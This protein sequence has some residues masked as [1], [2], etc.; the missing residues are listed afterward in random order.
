M[1]FWSFWRKIDNLYQTQ[2]YFTLAL[3]RESG[4]FS[5]TGPYGNLRHLVYHYAAT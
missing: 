2:S 5:I 3:V 1:R 4:R